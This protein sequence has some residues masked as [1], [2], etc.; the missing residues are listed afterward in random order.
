MFTF[1]N[2]K[3]ADFKR[4]ALS[5]PKQ[6]SGSRGSYKCQWRKAPGTGSTTYCTFA[7]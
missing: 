1:W 3:N 4:E 5:T 6:D 7:T 2:L